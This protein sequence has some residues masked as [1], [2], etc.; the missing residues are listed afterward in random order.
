MYM[1]AGLGNPGRKYEHTRH[2]SGFDVVDENNGNNTMYM[3]VLKMTPEEFDEYMKQSQQLWYKTETDQE[4]KYEASDEYN[5]ET[6]IYNKEKE[7]FIYEND[8]SEA[9][10]NAV[11]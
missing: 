2:N 1:I 7:I 10:L 11:G 5:N 6:I 4:V 9:A 8:F 3:S